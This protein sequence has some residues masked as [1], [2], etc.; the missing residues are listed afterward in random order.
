MYRIL[1]LL[2]A[3]L[4]LIPRQ[5]EAQQFKY[6]QP[7]D[8]LSDRRVLEIK[9]DGNGHVWFL[10]YTGLDRYDG[11]EF[12]HYMVDEES[13]NTTFYSE[14]NKLETDSLGG[15]WFICERGKTFK[16]NQAQDC[17]EQ[18]F[19]PSPNDSINN[20][21]LT[22]MTPD[23]EIW[24]FMG[25][26]IRRYNIGEG[27]CS[28]IKVDESH[29]NV[30]SLTPTGDKNEYYVGSDHG[31]CHMVRQDNKLVHIRNIIP[32][33]IIKNP[34]K[35]YLQPS[36]QRIFAAGKDDGLLIHD[37]V[38][39]KPEHR[40]AHFADLIV[41]DIVPLD[42][43]STL[44]ATQGAGVFRYLHHQGK[45]DLFF[46]V[47]EEKPNGMNG[48]NV[49]DLHVDEKGRVWMAV[50]PLGVTVFDHRS[51]AYEWHKTQPGEPQSLLN[52]QVNDIIQDSDGDIWYA[53][54]AGISL[55]RMADSTWTHFLHDHR[56][57]SADEPSTARKTGYS[58][59]HAWGNTFLAV[60][61]TRP[62]II[63]AGGYMTGIYTI[64]KKSGKLSR[65]RGKTPIGYTP[66]ETPRSN[67]IR[68]IYKDNQGKIWTCGDAYL[69]CTDMQSG[70]YRIYDFGFDVTCIEPTDS[71]RFYVGTGNGLFLLHP[72]TDSICRLNVGIPSLH[73]NDLYCHPDGTLYIG[74]NRSGLLVVR[75]DGTCSQFHQQ[76]SSLMANN[77][78]TIVPDGE[79]HLVLSTGAFIA[80][81]ETATCRF[82]NWTSD[83]G[84]PQTTFNPRAGIKTTD[85]DLI[86]GSNDGAIRWASTI[87]LPKE[88]EARLVVNGITIEGRNI[89]TIDKLLPDEF[90]NFNTLKRL[91][92]SHSRNH[93]AVCLGDISYDVPHYTEVMWRMADCEDT[94]WNQTDKEG[95]LHLQHLTPGTYKL[96][97]KLVAQEDRRTLDS[98]ELIIEVT[99]PVWMVW[100][101]QLAYLI[102]LLW[103]IGLLAL[104]IY[105][106]IATIR[107]GKRKE[108]LMKHWVGHA[109]KSAK[110]ATEPI[111]IITE[112]EQLTERG[113]HHLNLIRRNIF[114]YCRM[115]EQTANLTGTQPDGKQET[116]TR[117]QVSQMVREYIEWI[118]PMTEPRGITIKHNHIGEDELVCTN[119]KLADLAVYS[120]A[121]YLLEKVPEK[122]ELTINTVVRETEWNIVLYCP[123]PQTIA[124]D[125]YSKELLD[126]IRHILQQRGGTLNY[127]E[128][129]RTISVT[130]PQHSQPAG[131]ETTDEDKADTLPEEY[132]PL[133]N[134]KRTYDPQRI[135]GTVL[136]VEHDPEVRNLLVG[137]LS[138]E[139]NM[140]TANNAHTAM[141]LLHNFVINA[142]IVDS[143]FPRY[144]GHYFTTL[145]KTNYKTRWI[146]LVL[147]D[148]SESSHG[149]AA[150]FEQP[151]DHYL[152]T[153]LDCKNI[154]RTLENI[155]DMQ[156][157]PE[158]LHTEVHQKQDD[159]DDDEEDLEEPETTIAPEPEEEEDN[160]LSLDDIWN[161]E[162]LQSEEMPEPDNGET[163]LQESDLQAKDQEFLKQ[164][165]G[166]L[167]KHLTEEEFGAEQLGLLMD[168]PST[169]LLVRVKAL[170]GNSLATLQKNLRM[171]KACE[172]LVGGEHNITEISEQLGFNDVKYFREVFKRHYGMSP[173]DFIKRH[174]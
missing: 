26:R 22:V 158:M 37:L 13:E 133:P 164:V 172:M 79:D 124:Q 160:R 62:G 7:S 44:I 151:A 154:R 14:H 162:G 114:Q 126:T 128:N 89:T 110:M 84:L 78:Y 101:A 131:D 98:H 136:L 139:W 138:D 152:H 142:I 104:C 76:N 3:A 9:K 170:T 55:F 63:A 51:P 94:I 130:M 40:F 119:R 127:A 21:R 144:A 72:E 32:D 56:K 69:G 166:H 134:L 23:N 67:Y 148:G 111:N 31:I 108:H 47:Q 86:F 53:T 105:R 77:V 109:R 15:L 39:N 29:K 75:K 103:L 157:K 16:Y 85:G 143:K 156:Q 149:M 48:D 70:N 58:N 1:I 80:R 19:T 66:E 64:D 38:L 20:V 6:I 59:E 83:Q 28:E 12:K 115:L 60:C 120:L 91:Q 150:G 87:K 169:T 147:I 107:H 10:T 45:M 153:G 173:S 161:G 71:N 112:E 8:G 132:I 174:E 141:A 90:D 93:L 97:A 17:F 24:Y 159:E 129:M 163:E 34:D 167:L 82:V 146:P 2:L 155:I 11:K 118:T 145:L 35:V 95:W 4:T 61:E 140:L 73:V 46:A 88:I 41:T 117:H 27:M 74:T 92:L 25:T 81:M 33:S 96:Q 125:P 135:R 116:A 30:T 165:K 18:I 54:S 36:L 52:N 43:E 100:Q 42:E 50:Y 123:C 137:Y 106:L 113:S 102:I 65:V 68:A 57:V 168:I 5:A 121:A 122:G 99:H 171:E 49:R